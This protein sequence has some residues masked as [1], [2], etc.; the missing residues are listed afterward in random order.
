MRIS[1]PGLGMLGTGSLERRELS[2]PAAF[3]GPRGWLRDVPHGDPRTM[4]EL[5]PRFA[6]VVHA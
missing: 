1:C 5:R 6:V 3:L 2:C 4:E